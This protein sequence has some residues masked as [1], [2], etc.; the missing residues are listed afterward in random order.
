M[1]LMIVIAVASFAIGVVVGVVWTNVA[2]SNHVGR[3][4]GW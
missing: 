1:I 3:H 2:I 4:F